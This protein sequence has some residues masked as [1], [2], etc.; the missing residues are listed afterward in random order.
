MSFSD[1]M[2]GAVPVL[3]AVA[4]WTDSVI[5]TIWATLMATAFNFASV[6]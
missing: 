1:V 5:A 2:V 6:R 4:S 3:A